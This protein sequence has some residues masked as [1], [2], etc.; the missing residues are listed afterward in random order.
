MLLGIGEGKI[1]VVIATIVGNSGNLVTSE[2]F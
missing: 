1:V 2:H